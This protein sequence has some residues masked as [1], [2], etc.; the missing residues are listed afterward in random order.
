MSELIF[1]YNGN[2]INIQVQ[3]NEILSVI[4]DR[5]CLKVN[6]NRNKIY[7]LNNG[8]KLNEIKK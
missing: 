5:F 2:S 1:V 7:F 3:S 4:I 8:E 6:V